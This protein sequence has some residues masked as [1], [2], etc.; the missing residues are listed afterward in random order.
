M[1]KE[2]KLRFDE[3]YFEGETY[4]VQKSICINIMDALTQ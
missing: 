1:E 4:H 2:P 3:S